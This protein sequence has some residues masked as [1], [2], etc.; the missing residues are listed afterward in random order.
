MIDNAQVGNVE[1]SAGRATISFTRMLAHPPSAV[2]EAL[3]D[4]AHFNAW[5]NAA[6][7]IDGRVGGLFAVHSGPFHWTGPILAW[8]PPTLFEYEH[9]HEP[10]PE[11]PAGERTIVRWE[12]S[13]A[14][15]GTRLIF[16]Q[17]RLSTIAG[18]APGTHVVLDRLAASLD[19]QP[20]PDFM[21]HYAEV[22]PLYGTWKAPDQVP[23]D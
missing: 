10:C 6:A 22:E 13:P 2:W 7:T 17:S 19:G 15:E 12:L 4:P 5:Y 11:M 14:G 9:N 23:A 21:A 3:T 20:L 1:I 16:T 18:F 8:E